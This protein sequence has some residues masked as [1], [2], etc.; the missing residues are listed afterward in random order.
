MSTR[1]SA[2]LHAL[3]D[4]GPISAQN[5][6]VPDMPSK[7][8]KRKGTV[9]ELHEKPFVI[10]NTKRHVAS[11]DG[12]PATKK[13][14]DTR[15]LG[16]LSC[17]SKSYFAMVTPRLYER[18]NVSVSYHAHI[19][20]VIRTLEPF[21]SINQK[22]QLRKE[23]QYRGQQESFSNVI[24]PQ[25]KPRFGEY[26]RQANL[27]IGDP[28]K[29]HK[30]IVHRY[31]EE[32]LKNMTNLEVIETSSITESISKSLASQKN[33]RA[34]N[35]SAG[36]LGESEAKSLAKIKD[37]R[38]L[39]IHLLGFASPNFRKDNTP[40]SLI[41]NSRSTL[42]SLEIETGSFSS[43][44]LDDWPKSK[45]LTSLKS[46]SLT[47]ATID[48]DFLSALAN[49]VD[50]VAL[51]EL[52]FGYLSHDLKI[53]FEHLSNIFSK[54]RDDQKANIKLRSLE[55]EMGKETSFAVP[56]EQEA[57]VDARIDFI[58]S[59]DTLTCLELHDYGQ[60][61]QE[62]TVNPGLKSSL[63]RA[64]LKHEKLTKLKISYRGVTSG[65]KITCLE[66]DTIL[67]LVDNLPELKVFEFIPE[68]TKLRQAEIARI[69]CRGRNLTTVTLITGGS[70]SSLAENQEKGL[71]FLHS[72][73][74]RVLKGDADSDA[75]VF[76]WEDHSKIT[77]VAVDWMIWE[78][79]SKL[80][81]AKKGMKKTK[82]MSVTVG[83]Q[84]REVVYRDIADFVRVPLLNGLGSKW[85]DKVKNDIK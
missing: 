21:L 1:R 38:H 55:I 34:L 15:T 59:F 65:Y 74:E 3:Q 80:G 16:R 61:R 43:V 49:A 45:S 22:K 70:W 79:G 84:K 75:G 73:F 52:K 33:L 26:V 20:K 5:D 14:E 12:R 48:E 66:P 6:S 81:K 76:E 57:Y 44:F 29:N 46:F 30:F 83:K 2:R 18:I 32:A 42:R 69:I 11:N 25:K 8:A 23:G 72:I 64:I 62:I 9:S 28:G 19:P 27:F 54:A 63:V 51:E 7:R 39:A 24:D 60:Y 58:S 36:N 17:T 41:L 78:V 53:L 13:I 67:T 85:L 47:G 40:L 37:L 31:V 50:F 68:P 10:G 82:K 35:V 71:E 77:R 4:R 56:E